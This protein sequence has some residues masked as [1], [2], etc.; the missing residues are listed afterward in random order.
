MK[1]T[2]VAV[3]VFTKPDGS[4]LLSSRPDGKPYAGYWEFPGGKIEPYETVRDALV[5]E[6][7]EE[8]NVVI[9][10][11]TPWFSFMMVYSHATVRL[12]TWRVT[13]WHDVDERGMVGLEGQQFQWQQLPGVSVSPTLPGCVPIFRALSL[14]TIYT[15]TNAAEVGAK[16]YLQHLRASWSKNALNS[17]P[18]NEFDYSQRRLIQV[19]EKAMT[20]A[21]RRVF[22]TDVIAIGRECQAL[23]LINSD[24]ELARATGADGVHLTSHQLTSLTTRPDV[25]WVGASAHSRADLMRAA[26]LKC[27]FVVLGSVQ[28]TASH[29]GQAPLGWEKFAEIVSDTLV[30]VFAIGGMLPT[31]LGQ[32][33]QHGAHGIAM[34]RA[35]LQLTSLFRNDIS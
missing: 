8:L 9:D 16:E 21:Q 4:F 24:I 18:N 26:E 2:D 32:A 3:A 23:V 14:P 25:E 27:D 22:A 29:P 15:I 28:S 5:R 33:M 34:Q 1:V 17:S 19:R 11:C 10:Q 20:D 35:G 12:H 31:D 30:P 6:L 13:A 7:R